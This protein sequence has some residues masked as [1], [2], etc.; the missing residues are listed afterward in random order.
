M[1]WWQKPHEAGCHLHP[2]GQVH[3]YPEQ[4][5]R[6]PGKSPSGRKPLSLPVLPASQTA[7]DAE[8]KAGLG[9][10][11][12]GLMPRRSQR[13]PW[14]PPS[15]GSQRELTTAPTAWCWLS[16]EHG[17]LSAS[18]RSD[19]VPFHIRNQAQGSKSPSQ[20]PSPGARVFSCPC[21]CPCQP[22]GFLPLW[23]PGRTG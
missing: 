19:Q 18:R 3:S 10:R 12:A 21:D 6:A 9:C 15:S 20:S 16:R 17:G 22:G 14:L 5:P 13:S 8:P 7:S 2:R 11:E 23:K 1:P 4:A